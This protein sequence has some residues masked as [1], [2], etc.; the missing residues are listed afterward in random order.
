MK[1]VLFLVGEAFEDIELLYPFYK[2][3]DFQSLSGCIM[4]A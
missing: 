4:H 2:V 1:K 3:I